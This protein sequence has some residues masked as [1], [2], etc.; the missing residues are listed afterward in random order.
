MMSLRSWDKVM[1]VLRNQETMAPRQWS[2]FTIVPWWHEMS[3]RFHVHTT[4]GDNLD[5]S[6]NVDDNDGVDMTLG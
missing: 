5:F 3:T 4:A 1:I 6:A 2:M